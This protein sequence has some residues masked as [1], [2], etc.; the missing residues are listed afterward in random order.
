M[1]LPY[2][3][4]PGGKARGSLVGRANSPAWLAVAGTALKILRCTIAV[5]RKLTATIPTGR[6]QSIEARLPLSTVRLYYLSR[7]WCVSVSFISVYTLRRPRAFRATVYQLRS[8]CTHSFYFS[9]RGDLF[10]HHVLYYCTVCVFDRAN[11]VRLLP[12]TVKRGP[13][14]EEASERQDLEKER[15]GRRGGWGGE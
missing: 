11:G 4:L 15:S 2:S 12:T 3:A 10:G 9:Y 6:K 1:R 8:C 13:G 5:A 7:P 14:D